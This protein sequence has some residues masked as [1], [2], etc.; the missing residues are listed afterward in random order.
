[1]GRPGLIRH[2]KKSG[3]PGAA[4]SRKMPLWWSFVSKISIGT[5]VGR[6]SRNGRDR[7]RTPAEKGDEPPIKIVS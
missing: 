3:C 6:A 5:A 1:M 4:P 7:L 2:R